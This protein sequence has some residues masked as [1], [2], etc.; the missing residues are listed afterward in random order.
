MPSQSLSDQSFLAKRRTYDNLGHDTGLNSSK[1]VLL[2]SIV[3]RF[4]AKKQFI[5]NLA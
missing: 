5:N 4:N 1:P 2:I 3:Y